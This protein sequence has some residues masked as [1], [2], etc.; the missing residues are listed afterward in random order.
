[1]CSKGFPVMYT[2]R[3][4]PCTT[5]FETK[6]SVCGVVLTYKS[7]TTHTLQIHDSVMGQGDQRVLVRHLMC[8]VCGVVVQ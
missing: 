1:M 8:S 6:C 2:R 3:T 5:V 4:G 7:I